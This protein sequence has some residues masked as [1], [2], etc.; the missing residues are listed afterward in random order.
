[1]TLAQREQGLLVRHDLAARVH[2]VTDLVEAH[3]R[4]VNRN[5]GSGTRLRL[6]RLLAEAGIAPAM[7]PGYEREVT[8]HTEAA[9]AIASGQ[10]DACLGIHAAAQ[11]TLRAAL[12]RARPGDPA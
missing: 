9:L 6:D 10:A 8:T 3:A 2:G 4:F 12:P 5:A 7:L 11:A 1:V